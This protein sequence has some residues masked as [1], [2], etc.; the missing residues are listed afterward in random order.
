MCPKP[1]DSDSRQ[2]RGPALSRD[3]AQKLMAVGLGLAMVL[4]GFWQFVMKP[5]RLRVHAMQDQL[6]KIT[7]TYEE[8]RRLTDAA[9]KV[10]EAYCTV[11]RDLMQAMRESIPPD[12]NAVAWVSDRIVRAAATVSKNLEIVSIGDAGTD[13]KPRVRQASHSR[14]HKKKAPPPEVFEDLLFRIQLDSGY[15][16][17]GR[18]LASLEKSNPYMRVKSL[19]MVRSDREVSTQKAKLKVELVCAFPAFAP[20]GF[21]P[22]KRPT[23]RKL[24]EALSKEDGS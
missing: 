12:V 21:P 15:H 19:S 23:Q 13:R 1:S 9:P 2:N 4:A 20:D 17:L 7:R 6:A 10:S 8:N 5:L 18:F 3:D 16:E 11:G 14:R 22:A 24:D